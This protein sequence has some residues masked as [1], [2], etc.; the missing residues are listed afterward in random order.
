MLTKAFLKNLATKAQQLNP[1]VLTG[2]KGL[3]PQVHQEIDVALKAHE[4]IKVRLNAQ[5]KEARQ[6]M[7]TEITEQHQATLV[8]AIGHVIVLY[9]PNEDIAKKPTL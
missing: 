9:R 2:I 7:I 5:D 3:T 6:A 4:L 8:Q 1:V